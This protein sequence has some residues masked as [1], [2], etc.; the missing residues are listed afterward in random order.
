MAC[1]RVPKLTVVIGGPYGAGNYSMCGRAYSP[2]LL[3]VDVAEC[4]DLGD[5]RRA[6]GL[7]T[8]T[9]RGGVTPEEE[10]TLRERRS[11]SNT[12]P[13]QSLLLECSSVGRQL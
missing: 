3:F 7:G 2:A 6:G 11:E 1:A 5:G 10:E 4:A 8:M 12:K 9:V 13:R